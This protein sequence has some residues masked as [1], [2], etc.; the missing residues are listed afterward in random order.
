MYNFLNKCFKPSLE[1]YKN[2]G[3]DG[4]F[5]I[6]NNVDDIDTLDMYEMDGG[7]IDTCR[8]GMNL[9]NGNRKCNYLGT[10]INEKDYL[11]EYRENN[12]NYI[13][14]ID[15]IEFPLHIYKHI[16]FNFFTSFMDVG[17]VINGQ[18]K[19]KKETEK[20]IE[21]ENEKENEVK[22]KSEVIN[23]D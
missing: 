10:Q 20:E 7:N 22:N 13:F 16:F 18:T 6:C 15:P 19:I 1:N 9:K 5:L 2:E 23:R 3:G 14:G 11:N 17:P 4:Q 12:F 8:R 21:K